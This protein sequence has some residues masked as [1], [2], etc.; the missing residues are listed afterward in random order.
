MPIEILLVEDTPGDVRLTQQAFHEATSFV[1]IHVVSDGQQAMSFLRQ[2]GP[3]KSVPRPDLILL[4]LNL[5][6]LDGRNVLAIIK[7]DLELKSVPVF[8]VT[9]SDSAEDLAMCHKFPSTRYHKKTR[10]WE[11]FEDLA[12]DI[13]DLWRTKDK[14]PKPKDH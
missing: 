1:R 8:I 4:D 6:V 12:K 5:P 13:C 14:L 2:Q 9:S 3:Y 10:H 11:G 7:K